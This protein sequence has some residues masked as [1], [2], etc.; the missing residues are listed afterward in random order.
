MNYTLRRKFKLYTKSPKIMQ[1]ISNFPNI[2]HSIM[3]YRSRAV[4]TWFIDLNG[5][6]QTLF[7]NMYQYLGC[8]KL[9]S[10]PRIPI[11]PTTTVTLSD[12]T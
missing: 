8:S 9:S 2:R 4:E 11:I 7:E 6:G 10:T 1:H 5:F 12:H 3:K